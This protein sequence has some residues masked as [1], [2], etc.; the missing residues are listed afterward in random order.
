M[1]ALLVNPKLG[2]AVGHLCQY[3]QTALSPDG[4]RLPVRKATRWMSSAPEVLMRLGHK[5]RG[6]RRHQTLV[7][8]R[9]AAAAVCPPQTVPGYSARG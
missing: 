9:A 5:C 1:A 8:G 3:G 4:V 6:G 7:G 2:T